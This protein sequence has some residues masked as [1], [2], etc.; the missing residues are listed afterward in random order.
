MNSSSF[1]SI[2]SICNVI[3][4]RTAARSSGAAAAG[5][6]CCLDNGTGCWCAGPSRGVD[7]MGCCCSC[8]TAIDEYDTCVDTCLNAFFDNFLKTF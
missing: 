8:G 5:A 1:M 3:H 6:D 2:A 7:T 4:A